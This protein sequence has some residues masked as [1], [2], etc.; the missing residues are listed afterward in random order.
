M[1]KD[2]RQLQSPADDAHILRYMDFISFYSLLRNQ[3]LFFKRLDKYTDQ[4][5]GLLFDE[6]IEAHVKWL[7][8]K[9]PFMSISEAER[10][11]AYNAEHVKNYR[12]W[13]LSNSWNLDPNE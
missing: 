13:T 9:D 7:R 12:Q 10:R 5:E 3:T 11:A 4:L 2:N 8:Q 1:Y 6:T